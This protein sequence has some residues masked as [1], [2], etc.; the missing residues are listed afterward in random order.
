MFRTF[1]YRLA[2][3]LAITPFLL[4]LMF[5]FLCL[6]GNIVSGVTLD[7]FKNSSIYFLFSVLYAPLLLSSIGTFSTILLGWRQDRRQVKELGLKTK[8]LELKIKELE[9]KLAPTQVSN[10]QPSPQQY[11]NF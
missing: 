1:A 10:I 9:L 3:T 6:T 2:L 5:L 8:E 4:A 7:E 11:P